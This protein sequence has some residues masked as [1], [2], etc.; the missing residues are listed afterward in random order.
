MPR[1][2]FNKD[3]RTKLK[4]ESSMSMKERDKIKDPKQRIAVAKLQEERKRSR[5]ITEED[6]AREKAEQDAQAA[7]KI[8]GVKIKTRPIANAGSTQQQTEQKTEPPKQSRTYAERKHQSEKL[9]HYREQLE[10]L[11]ERANARVEMLV[12]KGYESRALDAAMASRPASRGSSEPMFKSDLRTEAQIK[13]ELSRTMAFLNDP[14]SLSKGA[15][16]FTEDFSA[17]GLFGGQ[18]R[19]ING[20]GYSDEVDDIIGKTT[21]DLYHRILEEAGGWERVMGYLK[22]NSGGLVEYGSEN[23]INAV[24]DMIMHMGTSNRAQTIIKKRGVDMINAMVK[25]YQAMAVQQRSGVDYGFLGY[26]D[27]AED[28]R[29]YWAWRM[30]REGIK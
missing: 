2:N 8:G 28:M 14:T 21:L 11:T 17:A 26:D 9:S 4:L 23:L 18:Y 7:P 10:I 5:T 20:K 6:I 13:R 22:A 30:E 1:S 27:E 25:D 12:N 16:K 24:Y 19:A 3:K 29:K 15:E